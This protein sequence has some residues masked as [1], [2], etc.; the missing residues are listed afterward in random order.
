MTFGLLDN[1]G[2]SAHLKILVGNNCKVPLLCEVTHSQV[3]GIREG[4][5]IFGTTMKTANV[6]QS[7]LIHQALC[8]MYQ[9][10]WPLSG[11]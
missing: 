7:L 9:A 5:D 8:F 4:T 11:R 10:T 2:Q 6:H 1:P 3:S